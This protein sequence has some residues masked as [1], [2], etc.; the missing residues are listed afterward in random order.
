MA[1]SDKRQVVLLEKR[2]PDVGEAPTGPL[3]A[4]HPIEAGFTSRLDTH[5]GPG[6]S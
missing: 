1:E 3:L 2:D 5:R 6:G 4:S